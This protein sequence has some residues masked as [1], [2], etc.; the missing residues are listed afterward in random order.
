[1]ANENTSDRLRNLN[2]KRGSIRAQ[3]TNFET[4]LSRFDRENPDFLKLRLRID[5]VKSIFQNFNDIQDEIEVVDTVTDHSQIRFQIEDK[6]FD[7]LAEAER[8]LSTAP[9]TEGQPNNPTDQSPQTDPPTSSPVQTR[10]KLKLPQASLPT[11][12]GRYEEW[13]SFQDTFKTM[14]DDQVDLTNVEK[15]Q[16][17]KSTLTGDAA[18][19]IQV[20]SITEDNYARAW[21]LLKKSYENKKILVSR[22]L[23]LL[24]T[25]PKQ[26]KETADG[27]IRLADETQQHVLSLA[28][29]GVNVNEEIIVQ[30]LEEKLHKSTAEKWDESQQGDR[31]PTLAE[32]LE[33]L[34]RT[35]ARFSKREDS[36]SSEKCSKG[37]AR[38]FNEDRTKGVKKQAFVT[39]TGQ[40]CPVCKEEQHLLYRC[41]KF[42]ALTVPQRIEIVK[43]N[44]LCSIC[45]RV[46]HAQRKCTLGN[47]KI[48]DKRHNTLLHLPK[49]T[50]APADQN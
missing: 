2:Q 31:F 27:L 9:R 46:N 48:C 23:H 12:S 37:I 18:R 13:M 1:M 5:R 36:K 24:L 19:K 42:R 32:M 21:N 10:H 34:Y 14:I 30:N 39:S 16:Y 41:G 4:F 44:K 35:A 43:D 15:L 6:F 20:F 38:S 8:I 49:E 11:F 17:L 50:P 33:F 28:S 22:H 47:C 45:L 25:L 40:S 29:L 7:A 3:L 26:E